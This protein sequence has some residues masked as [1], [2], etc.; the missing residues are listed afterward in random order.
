MAPRCVILSQLQCCYDYLHRRKRTKTQEH[1]I[2][3]RWNPD[4]RFWIRIFDNYYQRSSDNYLTSRIESSEF[5][6]TRAERFTT[7]TKI[8][9]LLIS[10]FFSS[11]LFSY[12]HF[13]VIFWFSLASIQSSAMLMHMLM[14]MPY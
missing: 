12:S 9:F 3:L 2:R 11:R 13:V 10:R 1:N 4:P 6:R 8:I 7:K 14:I 5:G